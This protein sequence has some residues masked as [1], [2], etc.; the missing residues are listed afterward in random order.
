MF[1][2][3][4]DGVYTDNDKENRK[5]RTENLIQRTGAFLNLAH[6]REYRQNELT[7]DK[8]QIKRKKLIDILIL[9]L[10]IT[11]LCVPFPIR[12]ENE[13]PVRVFTGRPSPEA[14]LANLDYQDVK[15]SD[16]W[17]KS[18]IWETGALELMKGYGAQRFGLS[19]ML[20]VE[21][22]IAVAYNMA[23]R[24][25]EAQLA[26]QA[27]D[28]EREK[29]DRKSFAPAMWSDGYLQ[30]AFNDGLITQEEY[31]DAFS[32]N[33]AAL[34]ASD[35]RRGSPV[36]RE[37]MAYY[38]ASVMGLVPVNAQTHLF[39]SY[40]DWQQSNPHRIPYIEA[41][42]QHRVMNGNNGRFDPKGPVTRE[43]AAQI[44]QNAEPFLF[45]RLNMEKLA[46]TIEKFSS[47][48][49]KSGGKSVKVTDVNVRS[50][51]GTLHQ[52][53]FQR[54]EQPGNTNELSGGK[55]DADSRGTIVNEQGV[56]KSEDALREGQR[57]TYFVRNAQVQYVVVMSETKKM[58]YGLARILS[59]DTANRTLRC[60]YL[61]DVPFP[62][63]R[64]IPSN[65]LS[66]MNFT[67]QVQVLT[68]SSNAAITID[69]M[70]KTLGDIRPEAMFL[71]TL[72]NGIVTA[73][74][75]INVDLFQEE[76]I[77]NGILQEINPVLGYITL[78][79]SDG[80]GTSFE[81][82]TMLSGLRT[83]SW[84]REEDVVVY[85]NGKSA[86]LNELKPGDSIFI[87]LDD[88][89]IVKRISGADNYY[90]IYGRVRTRGNGTLQLQRESGA[91]E[92]LQIPDNTP[93]FRDNRRISFSD[94]S[95]GDNIRLL[96][97]TS[98]NN[99]IIGQIDVERENVEASGIYRAQFRQ[100]DA[101]NDNLVVSGLQQF[102][103]G[104]WRPSGERGVIQLDVKG[105]YSPQIPKGA[106]G[107]VYFAMGED[108]LGRNTVVRMFLEDAG[109][110]DEVFSDTILQTQPGRG[111][112]TLMN[113]STPLKYDD[114]TLIIKGGKLLEPNQVKS[115]DE[116][117]IA[118][119]TL[120]DGSKRANV[121]WVRET[122]EDTG[123]T[124]LRGRITQ[125]DALSTVTL[126]SF[127]LFRSPT[128]E[129]NNVPKTLTID[130]SIT[131]I[132]DDGG[133]IDPAEF[134]D[135]GTNS[136]KNRS[137]YV[138]A[139]EGKALVI[140]TAPYGDVVYTGRI[141]KLQGA[142]RDDFGHV[143]T[144]PASILLTGVS[145]YNPGNWV[146]ESKPDIELNLLE[147]TVYS[148]NGV[149]IGADLLREGDRVTVIRTTSGDNAF[150]I[151]A[152]SY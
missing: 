65:L 129:F 107:T 64:L 134:D 73:M 4:S 141:G 5:Q 74:E 112:L 3:Y 69:L 2:L 121:L 48:Y 30:L 123:L 95:E 34:G 17:A 117:M 67:G 71:L 130:A 93:I 51:D 91:V 31:E 60:E 125:I 43:Q 106:Q 127:S 15:N 83:Y 148:R 76:G 66:G 102:V 105:G 144:P 85:K 44:L 135:I 146:W 94:I 41:L 46:G 75:K 90:P 119:G 57:I 136:F 21:Q 98:G 101:L 92:L 114:N 111:S 128:W 145:V 124:L 42:L 120:P 6:H 32:A 58:T 55:I 63:S 47:Y 82:S 104:V 97:Q 115:N 151:I 24:E 1:S 49:D 150:V 50:A 86:G 54:S 52:F 99:V 61:T 59:T 72:E 87:K 88:E 142:V 108:I 149:V 138:L 26:A 109:L 62:D 147:N 13:S 132:F 8:M 25:A 12:A 9:L 16:T 137:V 110:Q 126:Q 19:D 113:G 79:F 152:E 10:C 68:V 40:Q 35:F 84:L 39:N 20:T 28:L 23:G 118:A 81:A 56:L 103:N 38:V 122:A 14:V 80:S 139:Q 27:L 89:G 33:Q 133:R 37:D 29:A 70:R 45:A 116:A 11:L 78:Y 7:G 100:Y 143:V 77:V 96:M 36:T 22:A 53:R 140:S 18:A 131:R